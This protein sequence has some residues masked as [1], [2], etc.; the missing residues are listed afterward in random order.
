MLVEALQTRLQVIEDEILRL[1]KVASQATD[2]DDQDNYLRL[3]QDLQREAREFRH[4]IQ[5]LSEPAAADHFS[6]AANVPQN[7]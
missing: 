3:A 4:E 6:K 7:L 2:K 1:T 5:K